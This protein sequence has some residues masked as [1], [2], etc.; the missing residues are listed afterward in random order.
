M[1][2][3]PTTATP[4][5][6]YGRLQ[7]FRLPDAD[8]AEYEHEEYHDLE[9]AKQRYPLFPWEELSIFSGED[10]NGLALT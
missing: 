3:K 2:E 1:V 4:P 7:A 10:E 5:I 9:S 8:M 6:T